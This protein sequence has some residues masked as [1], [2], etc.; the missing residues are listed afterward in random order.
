MMNVTR[1]GR[2]ERRLC[3]QTHSQNA[4]RSTLNAKP[5]IPHFH[6]FFAPGKTFSHPLR[7][8]TVINQMV[9]PNR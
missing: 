5:S 6:F 4:K 2:D 9:K 8:N 7:S 1:N 3:L